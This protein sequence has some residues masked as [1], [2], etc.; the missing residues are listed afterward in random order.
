MA[1]PRK[2]K[3]YWIVTDGR[4]TA[5]L[6]TARVKRSSSIK[7]WLDEADH[8]ERGWRWW[9]NARFSC[10]RVDVKVRDAVQ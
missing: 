9:R 7:A 3:T 8:E 1:W 4:G 6:S 2:F 10:Q 5:Y